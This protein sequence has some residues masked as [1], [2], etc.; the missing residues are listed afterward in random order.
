MKKAFLSLAAV[1][2]LFA[3]MGCNN[4]GEGDTVSSVRAEKLKPMQQSW[5]GTLPCAD[6]EGIDTTLFLEKDGTWVMNQG[7]KGGKAPSEF[8]SYG[9]WARTADKLVLTDTDGEKLYFRAKG[10]AME[11]LDREGNPIHSQLNYVLQPVTAPL[12]TTPMAMRGMYSFTADRAEFADCV[13]GKRVVV[14]DAQLEQ[15]YK[16]VSEQ[17]SQPV[18]LEVEGHFTLQP[19]VGNSVMK[20]TLVVDQRAK[21]IAGK[22]CN[23]K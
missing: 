17:A 7:Y 21:F 13:T 12:P 3:L 18:L 1:M 20:K 16:S 15:Q 6:C 22:D 23:H 19:K 11:M 4:R 5:R 14:N 10:E 2:T 8:A 9:T